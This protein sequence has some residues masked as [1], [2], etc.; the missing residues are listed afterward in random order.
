M[1]NFIIRDEEQEKDIERKLEKGVF[2]DMNINLVLFDKLLH[3][4]ID[5]G[6]SVED[7]LIRLIERDVTG[8]W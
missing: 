7:Y 8:R 6:M 3:K 2:V 4:A 5:K 1:G